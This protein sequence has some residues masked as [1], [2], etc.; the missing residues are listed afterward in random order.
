[1]I[2][3]TNLEAPSH[4]APARKSEQTVLS[5]C[6]TFLKPEMLHVYRQ[7]CGI[8]SFR[9]LVVTRRHENAARFPCANLQVL[10]KSPFRTLHRAWHRLLSKRI[11]LSRFETTQLSRILRFNHCRLLHI[12]FGTEAARLLSWIPR[13]G[14][15]TVVSFHGADV[16][17]AL[18]DAELK[19]ICSSATLLLYRSDSLRQA[20]ISRGAPE[21]KLRLNPTGIPIP[22]YTKQFEIEIGKPLRIIQACRFIEKKG[23]DVTLMAAKQLID[24]G[25]NVRITLAG[26]GPQRPDLEALA[27]RLGIQMHVR[28]TGFLSPDELDKEYA[29]HDFFLHPSRETRSGDREGIP[30]SLLE[31][32]AHGRIVVATRHSG[33]PEAVEDGLNGLLVDHADPDLLAKAVLHIVAYPARANEMGMAAREKV[34]K[35]FSTEACIRKLE[36]CYSEA[37][38]CE[39]FSAPSSP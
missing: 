16:S 13:A 15:P 6:S 17:D 1:M 4:Q 38:D 25:H 14:V 10:K 27:N 19:Q 12:Y 39:Q 8:R 22:N 9:N 20:L 32:M 3:T 28:F 5:Y 31:A 34:I 18:S 33:I 35:H 26:D 21:L 29:Q 2:V 36:S 24:C 11:P 37:M 7:I 30:N 23:L